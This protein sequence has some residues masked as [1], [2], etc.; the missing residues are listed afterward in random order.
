V[1]KLKPDSKGPIL[2]ASPAL[3]HR[4]NLARPVIAR[5]SP[6][7][8]RMSLGGVRDEAE[9]RGHRRTYVGRFRDGH[10]GHPPGRVQQSGLMLDEI[11]KLGADFRGDPS[12]ALLEV[13]DPEQ[14]HSFQDHY[15]DVPS[16]SDDVHRHGHSSTTFRWPCMRS[17]MEVAA[18]ARATP[19]TMK[20]DRSERHV[21]VVVWK[22][23]FCSDQAPPAGPTT[24]RRGSRPPVCRFHPA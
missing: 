17:R 8:Y 18:A 9:I 24:G 16:T 4:Q 23:W 11:D 5:A 15:L 2:S 21:Q 22:E 14:N 1:R 13:L 12:S 10:P 7:F 19:R 3:R 20:I 6:Q